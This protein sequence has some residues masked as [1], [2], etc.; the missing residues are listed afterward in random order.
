MECDYMHSAI[1]KQLGNLEVYSPAGY[2]EACRS[3][4]VNPKPYKVEYLSHNFFLKYSSLKFI[5]S[6]RPGTLLSQT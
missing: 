1:E 3:A 5:N 6:L 4:R 2:F